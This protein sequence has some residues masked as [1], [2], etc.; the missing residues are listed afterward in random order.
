MPTKTNRPRIHW[1]TLSGLRQAKRLLVAVASLAALVSSS[2][3]QSF[4]LLGAETSA[5]AVSDDGSAVGGSFFVS[6][7][8]LQGFVWR[9]GAL[10]VLEDPPGG[11]EPFGSVAALSADGQIA[12]GNGHAD[13]QGSFGDR[14]YQAAVKWLD[15]GGPVVLPSPNP[16][17]STN[18]EIG[19]AEARDIAGDLIVGWASDCPNGDPFRMN[20]LAAWSGDDLSMSVPVPGREGRGRVRAAVDPLRFVGNSRSPDVPWSWYDGVFTTLSAPGT[21]PRVNDMS[22]DG[23][24]VV[25]RSDGGLWFRLTMDTTASVVDV[26]TL[27]FSVSDSVTNGAAWGVSDDGQLIVGQATVPDTVGSRNFAAIW[28]E[29]TG[30]RDLNTILDDLCV[31]LDGWELWVAAEVSP[32]GTVIVGSARKDGKF[33]GY[34]LELP[35]GLVGKQLAD[36]SCR[37]TDVTWTGGASD[38]FTD[39]GNWLDATLPGDAGGALFDFVG[40]RTV[41]LEQ[42]YGVGKVTVRGSTTLDL[43]LHEHTLTISPPCISNEPNGLVV[44][45]GAGSNATLRLHGGRV[46]QQ[47]SLVVVGTNLGTGT[48][49]LER[50]SRLEQDSSTVIGEVHVGQSQGSNG[51]LEIDD[52]SSMSTSLLSVAHSIG[53]EGSALIR[54]DQSKMNVDVLSVG[55]GGA[56]SA[57]FIAGSVGEVANLVAI[58]VFPGSVGDVTVAGQNTLFGFTVDSGL[59]DIGIEGRGSFVVTDSATIS[60]TD[61]QVQLGTRK[62]EG[63]IVVSG[64]ETSMGGIGLLNIGSGGKGEVLVEGGGS[65]QMLQLIVSSDPDPRE[66]LLTITGPGSLVETT[67]GDPSASI[68]NII[69]GAGKAL[70]KVLDGGKLV[71]AS[72]LGV[73]LEA[74]DGSGFSEGRLSVLNPL[75]RATIARN[76]YVG[77]RPGEEGTGGDVT[78]FVLVGGGA[79][80]TVGAAILVGLDK[81]KPREST[82][83][84]LE[85]ISGSTIEA[86]LLHVGPDGS[87]IVGGT[88]SRLIAPFFSAATGASV[89]GKITTVPSVSP[90]AAGEDSLDGIITNAL[91][92]SDGALIDLDSVFVEGGTLGG[93]LTWPRDLRNNGV[94]SPGDSTHGT[95]T[96]AIDANYIQ[97]P[98]GTL[99][100]ELKGL[101]SSTEH[102]VLSITGSATLDGTLRL[103]I[104]DGYR[105]VA[106]DRF[107]I[108][109]AGSVAGQFSAI[110]TTDDFRVAVTYSDQAVVVEVVSGV[111][112]ED[113]PSQLPS[114]FALYPNYPNPFNPT[115]TI[116]FDVPAVTDVSLIVYDMLGRIV[117]ELSSTKTP[118]GSHEIVFDAHDLPSGV[119]VARL[120]AGEKVLNRTMMLLK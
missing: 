83:G 41:N 119:Y 38:S 87:V 17:D 19:N 39:T 58:G 1:K 100:I 23:I 28:T 31:D 67:F 117:S 78:G 11:G 15:G 73:G 7:S 16:A 45:A 110:E 107:E 103:S 30:L 40:A 12:A 14:R 26:M 91:F 97:Q 48:L 18:C 10:T 47:E 29:S 46:Y 68:K 74:S 115:T 81:F 36:C 114:D 89:S 112:V 55:T 90:K 104:L 84:Q 25:G 106:G 99:E 22:S 86:A 63:Q 109:T 101:A 56:G 113:D 3:A 69:G 72:D 49:R 64:A 5:G 111:A 66:D 79:R 95:G 105:P 98:E 42:G 27:D 6:S 120:R 54:G 116:R 44:G 51:R 13:F 20:M 43:D 75:S 77:Y 37:V 71:I 61:T 85:V 62:G 21:G 53:A 76:L 108:L 96:F 93:T 34:R 50:Q 59:F 33:Q 70:A 60:L 4:Q 118:A 65:L 82:S 52:G 102:D 32:D 57:E 9:A 94:I 2:A 24:Y 88:G 80:M 35:R 92:I 8:T